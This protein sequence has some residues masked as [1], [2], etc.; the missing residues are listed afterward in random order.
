MIRTLAPLLAFSLLSASDLPQTPI[1]ASVTPHGFYSN[2]KSSD[3]EHSGGF[4]LYV[5][6]SPDG[7]YVLVRVHESTIGSGPLRRALDLHYDPNSNALTFNAK[8]DPRRSLRFSGTLTKSR[9]IGTFWFSNGHIDNHQTLN[10]CC[11]DAAR[12]KAYPS[13]DALK[14]EWFH[15]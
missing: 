8:I 6:D 12:F 11:E 10:R 13:I 4:H 1:T 7:I 5:W 2:E 14:Q 3:G 9:V 15:E